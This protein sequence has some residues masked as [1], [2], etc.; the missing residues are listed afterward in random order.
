[1]EVSV[2]I[3]DQ[4]TKNV[5][6]VSHR[7]RRGRR[8]LPTTGAHRHGRWHWSQGTVH[9]GLNSHNIL[10]KEIPETPGGPAQKVLKVVDFTCAQRMNEKFMGQ[11]SKPSFLEPN[12]LHEELWMRPTVLAHRHVHST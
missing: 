1:M 4:M 5:K 3:F 9:R 10:V 7:E 12:L 2:S 8:Q 6:Y 11:T